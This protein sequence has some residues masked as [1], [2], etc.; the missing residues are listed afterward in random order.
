MQQFGINK[1]NA[2]MGFNLITDVMQ[3]LLIQI[4]LA[5]LEHH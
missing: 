4:Y 2:D 5:T 1:K 3:N